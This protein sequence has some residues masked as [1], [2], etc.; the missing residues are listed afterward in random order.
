MTAEN[1][2]FRR[3]VVFFINRAKFYVILQNLCDL[4]SQANL[5][6]LQKS[7]KT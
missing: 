4:K 3:C 2:K 5:E 6:N 1:D 7:W